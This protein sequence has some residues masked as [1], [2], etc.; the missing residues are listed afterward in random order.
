MTTVYNMFQHQSLGIKINIQVTKLVLLRQRPAKLSIGHHGERS[1]ESFCHWQNEEYGGARYLG[2]NQV[3]GGKD[4][5]PPVDAAVFVTSSMLAR[6]RLQLLLTDLDNLL[7]RRVDALGGSLGCPVSQDAQLSAYA[8]ES[9]HQHCQAE[10]YYGY[11]YSQWPLQPSKLS[12]LEKP[13]QLTGQISAFTR[14]SRVTLLVSFEAAYARRHLDKGQLHLENNS[15]VF[16]FFTFIV[17]VPARY[18]SSPGNANAQ[19]S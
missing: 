5:A 10:S 8:W 17:W 12:D 6:E 4:D 13:L 7:G 2:N 1:L 16:C 14:M 15:Q 11:A 18:H 9:V 19:N 3:P